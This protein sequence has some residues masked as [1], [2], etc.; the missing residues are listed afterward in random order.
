[1]GNNMIGNSRSFTMACSG[2]SMS[3]I[4]AGVTASFNSLTS[5][6]ALQQTTSFNSQFKGIYDELNNL[7]TKLQDKVNSLP[8]GDVSMRDRGV[9][10]AWRYEKAEIELGGRGTKHW[11][12]EERNE[13]LSRGKVRNAEGHHINNVADHPKHQANPDNIDFVRDRKEHLKKHGGDFRNSTKGPMYDRNK[14]LRIANLK[15]VA[16]NELKGLGLACAIGLG[17]GFSMGFIATLASKG[18]SMQSFKIAFI[19]GGKSALEGGFLS[20]I[21]YVAVRLAGE[22]LNKSVISLITG[23][24][25]LQLT[26]NLAKMINMGT[27]G[28][29]SIS[30]SAAIQ[31]VKLRRSGA[32][33]TDAAVL[34][35][36][37]T[38]ISL[39]VLFISIAAQG[40]WGGHAGLIVSLAIAGI[41]VSY[42]LINL[43]LNKAVIERLRHYTI[44]ELRPYYA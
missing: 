36:K 24:T 22:V 18:V 20:G 26:E 44:T 2:G 34:T 38:G 19:N 40:I 39:A 30:I 1:M 17:V 7:R 32:S 33:R 6:G 42:N 31:Y 23:V 28:V 16:K 21:N 35:L 27:L 14:R 43:I 25:G 15:R 37:N 29:I 3:G 9:D 13:I 4:S 10:L 41:M 5:F 8:A 12:S 11:S